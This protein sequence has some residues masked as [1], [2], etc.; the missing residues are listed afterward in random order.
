MPYVYEYLI[1]AIFISGTVLVSFFRKHLIAT[2]LSKAFSFLITSILFT[3]IVNLATVFTIGYSKEI[4]VWLN[5]LLNIAYYV[6]SSGISI[7]FCYCIIGYVEQDIYVIAAPLYRTLLMILVFIINLIIITTPLHKLVFYFDEN[8][9]YCHGPFYT[10]PYI[11]SVILLCTTILY[12]IK[13]RKYFNHHQKFLIIF[14]ILGVIG[15]II[16]QY[17]FTQEL[18][19]EFISAITAMLIF[20]SLENPDIYQD[21]TMDI[22]SR[23]AFKLVTHD[24]FEKEKKFYILALKLNGVQYIKETIGFDNTRHLL[25]QVAKKIIQAAKTK[26]VFRLSRVKIAIILPYDSQ[27][28]SKAIA[29][30]QNT[31]ASNFLVGKNE[32]SIS[33]RMV[34]ISC[35]L[36]AKTSEEIFE[37]IDYSTQ[38]I[39]QHKPG[40]V[41]TVTKETIDEKVKEIQLVSKLKKAILEN[42]FYMVYQPIYSNKKNKITTA[43][44]L[45]RLNRDVL[46]YPVG[47]DKFIPL[48]EENG[49]ILNIGQFVFESVCR[50]IS[51][52]KIWEK[53][54]EYIH[55]NLSAIQCMQNSLQEQLFKIM[56]SYN[57]DHKLIVLEITETSAIA[58]SNTLKDNMDSLIKNGV[59]FAMDD[60]GSGFSNISSV[61]KYPFSSVKIDKSLIDSISTGIRA[62]TYIKNSITMLKE[63]G[64][65]IVAEGVETKEQIAFLK[66]ANCDYIQGYFYSKPLNEEDFIKYIW[67]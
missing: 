51:E 7:S 15:S 42:Q 17:F 65:E 29:E 36:N 24:M 56:D 44:A 57:L 27:K 11:L 58:S 45:I 33:M 23:A 63:L 34:S 55:V 38:N 2:K 62:K 37:L 4:P 12:T 60:F 10:I 46:D 50:F 8:L 41:M 19:I 66:E 53:G 30:L 47:P 43:E 49:L 22:Y 18:F 52:Q 48:A 35:P 32:V 54:I 31:F 3:A 39:E 40:Y 13:N 28:L 21:K 67:K 20:L 64:L 26:K 61:V 1:A 14:Y 9:N 59:H 5:Y 6:S 16:L 25:K